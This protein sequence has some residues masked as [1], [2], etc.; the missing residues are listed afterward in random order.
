MTKEPMHVL[1]VDDDDVTNFLS[2]EMLRLFM[3]GP[4]VDIALNGQEAIDYLVAHSNTGEVLPDLILLDINMPIMNGWEFLE[5]YEKIRN[6]FPK[7][8]ALYVVSS[9]VDDA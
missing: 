5:E 8:M 4:K 2:K 7:S 6:H 3:G 9:S 1:L